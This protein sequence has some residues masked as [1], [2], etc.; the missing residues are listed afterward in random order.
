MTERTSRSVKARDQASGEDGQG[1]PHGEG[2]DEGGDEGD[3]QARGENDDGEEHGERGKGDEGAESNALG[4]RGAKRRPGNEQARQGDDRD[5]D[6]N[7]GDAWGETGGHERH[8]GYDGPT[9]QEAKD[10]HQHGGATRGRRRSG[11]H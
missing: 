10:E 1:S 5:E 8:G 9:E 4:G 6:D 7:A 11:W 3:A 2:D